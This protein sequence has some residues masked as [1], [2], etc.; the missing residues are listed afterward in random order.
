MAAACGAAGAC[1]T[2]P[3][4]AAEVSS[5]W[6]GTS[7]SWG[8]ASKW[9]PSTAYPTN[10]NGGHTYDVTVNSGDI[11]LDVN[12]TVRRMTFNGGTVTTTQQALTVTDRL[13]WFGGTFA[14]G[15][16]VHTPGGFEVSGTGLKTTLGAFVLRNSG[17]A[18][19]AGS[20]FN[21]QNGLILNQTTGT[22][23]LLNGEYQGGVFSNSATL[24]KSTTGSFT[25]G[26]AAT[27]NNSGTVRVDA[28][29]LSVRS[30]GQHNGAFSGSGRVE[31]SSGLTF[32]AASRLT[33]REVAFRGLEAVTVNGLFGPEVTEV[34]NALTISG[35]Q[36]YPP[37]ARLT[38]N[39]PQS[40]VT[41]ATDARGTGAAN[42]EVR[43]VVGSKVDFTATQHLRELTVDNSTAAIVANGGLAAGSRVIHTRG[44]NI[45]GT[46]RVNLDRHAMIVDH[47]GGTGAGDRVRAAVIRGYNGGAW[48]G[49]GIYSAPAATM[50]GLGAVGYAEASD[51]LGISGAQTATYLGETVDATA[52]LVRFTLSGDAD[53]NGR[54]DFNDLVRLAQNYEGGAAVKRWS[55]GDFTYD[56][57]VDFADLVKLAQAY[58][59][60]LAPSMALPVGA[61]VAFERDWARA[62]SAVPEPG[63]AVGIIGALAGLGRRRRRVR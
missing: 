55:Q 33:V 47:T 15:G 25:M 58:G 19:W 57:A 4:G 22:I 38:L 18:V 53:L 9:L 60:D 27:F 16:T 3:A 41:M 24:L 46:G 34:Q 12:P 48:D 40:R 21:Q 62:V 31:F 49:P 28:G 45:N 44:L 59:V 32:Q 42:L 52:V 10:G 5:F 56:G 11:T 63:A 23:H 14:G 36:A 2:S 6:N 17:E 29:T 1:G 54:V 39:T 26:A 30:P 20:V 43:A 51:V 35:P 7:G 50:N 37:N 8:T 13:F 61:S